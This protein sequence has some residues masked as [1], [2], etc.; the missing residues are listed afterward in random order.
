V[1]EVY[2]LVL[3]E[4]EAI[5]IDAVMREKAESKGSLCRAV[6]EAACRDI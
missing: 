3:E 4:E 2:H 5:N 1:V 6:L